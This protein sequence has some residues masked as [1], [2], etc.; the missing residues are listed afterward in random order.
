MDEKRLSNLITESDLCELLGVS[1]DAL[2]SLRNK[3]GLPYLKVNQNS[4]VYFEQDVMNWLLSRRTVRKADETVSR[5]D[6]E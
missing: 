4:R 5:S 3:D 1:K 2:G 6:E